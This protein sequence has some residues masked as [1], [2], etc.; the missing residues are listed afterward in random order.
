MR[1]AGIAAQVLDS[2]R[3]VDVDVP[4]EN[5]GR[6]R[7]GEKSGEKTR[8]PMKMGKMVQARRARHDW[9]YAERTSEYSV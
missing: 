7:K 5:E 2:S 9:T 1:G 6:G 8:A 3:V 4:K